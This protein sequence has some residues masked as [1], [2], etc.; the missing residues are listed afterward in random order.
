GVISDDELAQLQP[1]DLDSLAVGPG[2]PA[3]LRLVEEQLAAVDRILAYDTAGRVTSDRDLDDHQH[4]RAAAEVGLA[5]GLAQ[6]V[7]R[8][9]ID[10]EA[11]R[12]SIHRSELLLVR[13]LL[14]V[15]R[16]GARE[17][18]ALARQRLDLIELGLE[19]LLRERND[20]LAAQSFLLEPSC[21]ALDI[22]DALLPGANSGMDKGKA[23]DT[24]PSLQLCAE[25][26]R[27]SLILYANSWTV[28]VARQREAEVRSDALHEREMRV[29]S[30]MTLAVRGL[31]IAAAV[32]E[33]H[34]YN[35]TGLRPE[36]L[37]TL[38]T[39]VAGFAVVAAGV[40]R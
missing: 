28:G 25:I 7:A 39:N 8:V 29:R 2:A 3:H 14:A 23:K 32:A 6:T 4:A 40:F 21:A 10:A 1:H 37:A 26:L 20:L 15:D 36:T 16:D 9:K 30:S 22:A 33:L 13:E 35:A 31:W 17:I 12:F 27:G 34:R 5:L 19:A 11:S 18:H 38:L 24:D